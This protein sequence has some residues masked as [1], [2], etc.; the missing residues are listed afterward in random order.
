MEK[1]RTF[2]F[3]YTFYAV[4]LAGFFASLMATPVL[5][6]WFYL[7]PLL[8]SILSVLGTWELLQRKHTVSRNYPLLAH[9]RYFLESI[10]PEIR[11]YFIQSD[12]DEGSISRYHREPGGDL[13]WEIG[14]GYFGC[15]HKDGSFNEEMFARNATTDQAPTILPNW[16]RSISFAAPRERKP[17]RTWS[18]FHSSNPGP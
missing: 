15:R 1:T 13:V 9:F 17:T 7:V 14:S 10:G 16:G 2:P 18:C 4:S 11:Q 3:R 12:T 6:G 5:G 8:F